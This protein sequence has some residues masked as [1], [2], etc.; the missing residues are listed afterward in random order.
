MVIIDAYEHDLREQNCRL[1][2]EMEKWRVPKALW[3]MNHEAFKDVVKLVAK[4]VD[5]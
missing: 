3:T 1:S 2:C 5:R 4:M